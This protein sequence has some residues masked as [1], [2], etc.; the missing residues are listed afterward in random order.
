MLENAVH[1]NP[2]A[3]RVALFVTM[4]LA[5]GHVAAG[6]VLVPGTGVKQSRVG[7]DFE[8]A[9]WKYNANQPKS[10]RETD[11]HERL[12]FGTSANGRWMEGPHRGT[13]DH[14]E[15]VQTPA[16][17]LPGSNGALLIRTLRSGIPGRL[18]FTAQQ[19]D[20]LVVTSRRLGGF[21]PVSRSPNVVVRVFVPPL[22][23]WERRSGTS[24]AF[25]ADLRGGRAN[26]L[27]QYWPGMFLQFAPKSQRQ[28]KDSAHIVLRAQQTGHDFR[29]PEITETG[30]WTM[31]MSFTPDGQ[32]HFFASPGVDDLTPDDHLASRFCYGFRAR[33]F[34]TFFFNVLSADDGRTW[35]T[36]WIID[37]PSLYVVQRPTEQVARNAGAASVR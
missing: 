2:R 21:L 4:L 11:Q 33:Q 20:L 13:P 5:W 12:P 9:K 35:S 8:D 30:W 7:D 22:E 37:D 36:P 29:G 15:R 1:A 23:Q 32:V 25:R 26:E 16:G 6:G 31:G 18:S 24:F 14:V 28:S 3:V 19:D 10:S 17:G 27:E 34:H